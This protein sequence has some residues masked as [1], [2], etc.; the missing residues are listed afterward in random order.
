MHHLFPSRSPARPLSN[1]AFLLALR[2]MHVQ[3]TAHGF[4]SAF[5]DWAAEQTSYPHDVCGM[6]QF[7]PLRVKVK[8]RLVG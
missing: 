6:A 8:M 4:R 5:R 7:V 2:R 1:M 3:V